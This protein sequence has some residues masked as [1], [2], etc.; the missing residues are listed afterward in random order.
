MI[1]SCVQSAL[2]VHSC[3]DLGCVVSSVGA[4][5]RET[6]GAGAGV[7]TG[8]LPRITIQRHINRHPRTCLLTLAM[9]IRA[10]D[11]L[12]C[13]LP[14]IMLQRDKCMGCQG[15]RSTAPSGGGKCQPTCRCECPDWCSGTGVCAG[16]G[17]SCNDGFA[18]TITANTGGVV[19]CEQTLVCQ[20]TVQC[21][22]TCSLQWRAALVVGQRA[23]G[24]C[25]SLPTFLPGG[26]L[27]LAN[28]FQTPAFSCHHKLDVV[29]AV[30][31]SGSIARAD[32][33]VMLAFVRCDPCPVLDSA[34]PH[35]RQHAWAALFHRA[36]QASSRE[37]AQPRVLSHGPCPPPAAAALCAETLQRC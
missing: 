29:F 4:D 24:C 10:A 26:A 30:D 15:T 7:S 20:P 12:P 16:I 33:D 23:K 9:R 36:A 19:S 22:T 34:P 18:V 2:N 8:V 21:Q 31:G 35:A 3:L 13:T 28:M 27:T 17:L 1:Q 25:D 32:F 14:G 11:L 5:C 37:C 6:R